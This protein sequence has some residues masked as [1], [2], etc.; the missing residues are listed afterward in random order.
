MLKRLNDMKLKL[1]NTLTEK[2]EIFQPIDQSNITMYVCGPTVYA[3]A[4]LGNAR[5][6]VVYDILYRILQKIFPKITY[7]RNITDVDD[8][9]IKAAFEEKTTTTK[10]AEKYTNFFH[11]DMDYLLCLKPTFEPKATNYI[12]D[13]IHLIE[14]LIEQKKAYI[15]NGSVYFDVSEFQ[16]YGKLSKRKLNDQIDGARIQQNKDKDDTEDFVLWKVEKSETDAIFESPWGLGRPGWHIEC[17]A[18]TFAN[19]G[20]TFDIHGGGSDLKFPHH[21][22]EIAQICAS[23]KDAHYAKYWVHN[24]FLTVE[25]QKMSKSLGNFITVEDIHK[26]NLDGEI[27]RYAM[28]R[29]HYT[30]PFDWSEKGILDAKKDLKKLCDILINFPEVK[31]NQSINIHKKFFDNL[32]DDMN[33]SAALMLLQTLGNSIYLEKDKNIQIQI[34]EQIYQSLLFIGIDLFILID[35]YKSKIDENLIDQ[36]IKERKIAKTEKNFQKSDEIRN[37][38]IE[39]GIEIKDMKN[40]EIF[41]SRTVNL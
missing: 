25:G 35:K 29:T 41:W 18:M 8:K 36:L 27:V 22:N 23:H 24:G 33:T 6:V 17:S 19:F 26:Q 4:H 5:S 12:N 9:I 40:G 7:L 30:Q 34:A 15:K 21:E 20:H 39:S 38:L 13:M 3:R 37:Q 31:N 28:L 2:K 10:I 16:D 14:K 11:Q 1:Y 32:L